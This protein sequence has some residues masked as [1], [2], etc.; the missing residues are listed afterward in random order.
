MQA[1]EESINSKQRNALL[2]ANLLKMGKKIQAS[3]EFVI[4]LG[5]VLLF[6]SVFLL[7]IQGN[8]NSK[9]IEKKNL[10]V[11]EVAFEV[12]DEINL[13]LEARD[14]YRREFEIPDKISNQDYDITITEEMIYLNTTDGKNALALPIPNVTGNVQKGTNKVRKDNGQ[15]FINQ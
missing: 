12:Q 1:K 6:F 10:M 5:F 3:I 15:I 7:I 2:N 13:A 11:K 8:M 9:L 4:M 14:G